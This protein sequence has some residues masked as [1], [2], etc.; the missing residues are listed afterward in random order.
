MIAL[1]M[2]PNLGNRSRSA[3][4]KLAQDRIRYDYLNCR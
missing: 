2:T 1:S 4:S 3:A